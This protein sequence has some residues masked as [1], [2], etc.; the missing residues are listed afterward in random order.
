MK[1]WVGGQGR[2]VSDSDDC[3]THLV[4]TT[5]DLAQQTQ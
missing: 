4:I 2:V 5:P 1:R 3:I